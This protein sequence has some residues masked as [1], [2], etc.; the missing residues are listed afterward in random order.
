ML[1]KPL[2]LP[3]LLLLT[4]K[5][6]YLLSVNLHQPTQLVN[7]ASCTVEKVIYDKSLLIQQENDKKPQ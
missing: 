1:N 4:P 6:E 5:A 3:S 2:G 7:G